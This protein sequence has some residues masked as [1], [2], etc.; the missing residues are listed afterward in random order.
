MTIVSIKMTSIIFSFD[1]LRCVRYRSYDGNSSVY[2]SLTEPLPNLYFNMKHYHP[3][4]RHFV[5]KPI[6]SIITFFD[7]LRV[8]NR[9]AGAIRLELD[10]TK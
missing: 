8:F 7:Q 4:V 5:L 2:A 10:I 9:N 6:L 3:V 1:R